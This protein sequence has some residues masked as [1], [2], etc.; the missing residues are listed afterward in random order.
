MTPITESQIR[1]SF[2]NASRKEV[3]DVSLPA[4][5]DRLDWERLEFL[6]WRDRKFPQ[7]GYVVTE[8]GDRLVGVLLK[9]ADATPRARAQC[10]W[11]QDVELADEVVFY[12]A[13]LAGAAGRKGDTIGTLCCADFGCSVNARKRP[14]AVYP[15]FD[16]DAA[17]AQRVAGLR[18]RVSAFAAAV[19]AGAAD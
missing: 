4:D 18:E 3:S 9:R 14:P 7:R 19:L 16:F 1:S 2:V 10:T 5:F 12:S 8:V 15:G 6:G 11:C 13:R 17:K